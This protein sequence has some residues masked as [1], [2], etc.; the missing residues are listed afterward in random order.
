MHINDVRVFQLGED[1][2]LI[3]NRFDRALRDNTCLA[4]CFHRVETL[5]FSLSLYFPNFPETTLS[6]T[7]LVNEILLLDSY[8]RQNERRLSAKEEYL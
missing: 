7:V 6:D 8:T 1:A 2:P 3:H 4:H 5:S